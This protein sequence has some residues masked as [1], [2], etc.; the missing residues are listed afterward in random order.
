MQRFRA[1]LHGRRV[2]LRVGDFGGQELLIDGR[3]V[4]SR[5]F[6]GCFSLSPSSHADLVGDDG[7]ARHLELRVEHSGWARHKVRVRLIVDGEDRALIEPLPL[8]DPTL[9]V[10]CGYTLRGLPIELGE[11]RCPECGRHTKTF[12]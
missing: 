3:V 12:D 8:T 2:E 1:E 9:C 7:L 11:V 4:S 10:N 6:A 5:P